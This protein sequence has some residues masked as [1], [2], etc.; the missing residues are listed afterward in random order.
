MS[1]KDI[2]S[3]PNHTETAAIVGLPVVAIAGAVQASEAY[4]Y[5]DADWIQ[6]LP[7]AQHLS[8][9]S[10][11]YVVGTAGGIITERFAA[12][13]EQRGHEKSAARVR[14]AGHTLTFLGSAA[15]QVAVETTT[16]G[17]GDKWDVLSGIIATAPGMVAGSGYA[18]ILMPRDQPSDH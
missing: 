16:R 12:Y 8:S 6:E 13:F 5:I 4:G 7:A 14:L 9:I 18:K 3:G 10:G 1:S 15:C 2:T 17:I 11:S